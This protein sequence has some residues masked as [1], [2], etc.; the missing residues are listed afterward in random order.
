M[1]FFSG[2]SVNTGHKRLN[3][4]QGC[5]ADAILLGNLLEYSEGD[6]RMQMAKREVLDAALPVQVPG[7]V[8]APDRLPF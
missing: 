8:I 7:I 5:L 4:L 6:I 3:S 2:E 1:T